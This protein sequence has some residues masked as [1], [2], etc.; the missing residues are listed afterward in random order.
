MTTSAF[1]SKF[2][3]ALGDGASPQSYT[4][5][6]EVLSVTGV[7]KTNELIEVTN[8]DS[9]SSTK[10][11]IAGLAEGSEVTVECN[12]K[13]SSTVQAAL[14]T[15]VDGGLTKNFKLY[16]TNTSPNESWQFDAVCLG[17]QIV[18]WPTEQNKIQ[19][20]LKI[21]GDIQ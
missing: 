10:E 1:I 9:P 18:P 7:G 6:E 16:H 12:F 19:F 15:H 4:D 11:F 5:I 8:F 14:I 13:S 3:L 2:K 21:T 17:W 20:T